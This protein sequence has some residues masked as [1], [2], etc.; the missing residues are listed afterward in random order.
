[1]EI[2]WQFRGSP[3]QLKRAQEAIKT[4]FI[5]QH[6]HI[7]V[8]IEPAPANRDE[9]LIAQM[10]AGTAPDVIE[11]WS[12]NVQQ[13]AEKGQVLNVDPLVKQNKLDISDFY[14]WQW[15]DFEI[16]IYGGPKYG[17]TMMRF[18]LPKYVN[19][20]F[21]WINKNMFQEKDVK[22]FDLNST[23]EDYANAMQK[24][25][26]MEGNKVK[27]GG[28]WIP[29]DWWDRYWYHVYMWGGYDADPKDPVKCGL[30]E[31]AA[32]DALEWARHLEWD[33]HVLLISLSGMPQVQG[34]RFF[35]GQYAIAEDGFYPFSNA[36]QNRSTKI[37]WQY[38]HVPKGPVKREV[39]GTTDGFAGWSRS[40][41]V[42]DAFTLMEYLSG[43]VYQVAQVESTGLLPIRYS[44]LDK[45]KSICI[46]K[47]PELEQANLDVGPEAMKLG[48]PGNRNFFF[49]TSAA[50][51][52]INPA[53]QKLYDTPGTPTTYFQ[54]IATQVTKREQQS[55]QNHQKKS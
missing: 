4:S 20:M 43:P 26:V 14:Q 47:Y 42:D 10:I 31:K 30:G 19:V 50:E 45:W 12:D 6:P 15:R 28:A 29:Y 54:T 18:G 24:L 32:Q 36:Q 41:H 3:D 8:V 35:S 37:D 13:F 40:K 16:P 33:L 51:L 34:N 5:P 52:I 21:C 2:R 46:K 11:T 49:N 44:V 39:L 38:T 17:G 48:Y 23:Y 55:L 27:V 1:M 22:I 25:T 9:K 7:K 53:L